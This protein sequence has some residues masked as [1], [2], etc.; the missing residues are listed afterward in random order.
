MKP[1]QKNR[2]PTG[3]DAEQNP[4]NYENPHNGPLPLTFIVGLARESK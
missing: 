2:D 4:Y 1:K 3:T